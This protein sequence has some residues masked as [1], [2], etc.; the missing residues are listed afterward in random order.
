MKKPHNLQ[1]YSSFKEAD[2]A[3]KKENQGLSPEARLAILHAINQRIYGK[4]V[5]S[6]RLQR[7]LEVVSKT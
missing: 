2:I 4:N 5:Y 7:V 3:K 1:C 6:R